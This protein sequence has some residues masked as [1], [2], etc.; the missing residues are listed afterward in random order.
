M[1]CSNHVFSNFQWYFHVLEFSLFSKDSSC[2]G[3]KLI[4]YNED[5]FVM[6]IHVFLVMSQ[7][8]VP[9]EIPRLSSTNDGK[10]TMCMEIYPNPSATIYYYNSI[11]IQG[12]I[13]GIEKNGNELRLKSPK[14]FLFECYQKVWEDF[15]EFLVPTCFSFVELKVYSC[16]CHLCAHVSFC[17]SHHLSIPCIE[18]NSWKQHK[19]LTKFCCYGIEQNGFPRTWIC[20][21]TSACVRGGKHGRFLQNLRWPPLWWLYK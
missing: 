16:Y 15:Y 1:R 20:L 5:V 10:D 19:I 18:S 7:D 14:N 21:V 13:I 3:Y 2:V 12:L 6:H 17:F 9:R 4:C 8:L 11:K